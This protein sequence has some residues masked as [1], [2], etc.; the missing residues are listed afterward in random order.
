MKIY[1]PKELLKEISD[2]LNAEGVRFEVTDETSSLV[3]EGKDIA[4]IV[5]V[6][7]N[8]LETEVPVLL[9][10]G[11]E[12]GLRAFRLPSGTAFLLTDAAGNFVRLARP[13]RGWER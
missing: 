7:V 8:L 3:V 11:F 5:E 2:L 1:L 4:E 12:T 6:E 9:E 13:P 10:A